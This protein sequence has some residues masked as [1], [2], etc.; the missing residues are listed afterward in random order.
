M[1]PIPA[2][3]A[4]DARIM[5][6]GRDLAQAFGGVLEAIPGS[7][8]R[9]QWLARTLGVNTVLT[10][11]ILKMARQE[12]PLA[13]AYLVPGPEPL[14][15]VLRAAER[16]RVDA[17]LIGRAR[18][19]VATRT[20]GIVGSICSNSFETTLVQIAQALNTLRRVFPLSLEPDPATI[21]VRVNGVLIPRDIVN[22][23]QYRD[24][25]QSIAFLGNYVPPP[26]AQILVEYAISEVTP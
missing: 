12:D 3:E 20:G 10:S 15:R 6:V 9:P 2:A 22:G 23:W 14:R 19:A 26:A 8:H 24:E 1:K 5:G 17:G 13:V 7:P 16:K 11:R 25:T 4:L 21:S 18:A